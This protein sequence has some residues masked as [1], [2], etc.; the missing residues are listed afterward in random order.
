VYLHDYLADFIGYGESSKSFNV[1]IE[2][3]DSDEAQS[4]KGLEGEF[5]WKWLED[6]GYNDKLGELLLKSL[7]PALL[8]D[9]CQF[10][11]EALRCSNRGRLT[12]AYALLRKPL[13]EDLAYLEWMLGDPEF[14]LT[15]LYNEPAA[16]LALSV[17]TQRDRHLPIIQAAARRTT[18]ADMYNEDFIY[19]LRYTKGAYYGFDALWNKALHLVT[20]HKE[21]T[22]EPQ[23]LNFIFSGDDA[24][25]DQWDFLYSRLPFLLFYTADV[26][27]SLMT[28]ILGDLMPN[29]AERIVRRGIGLVACTAAGTDLWKAKN[30][31]HA[32]SA[33][34]VMSQLAIPCPK[35]GGSLG[36]PTEEVRTLYLNRRTRCASCHRQVTIADM[37]RPSDAA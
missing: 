24:R 17:L 9:F 20:T 37:V 15:T 30:E 8:A 3:K 5:I 29:A 4:L 18:N 11:Y 14:L 1:T 10:T 22:T 23:N 36:L 31:P 16:A 6:R 33:D 7:F 34:H 26:C 35:C 27:E 21:L 32:S 12:V 19:D 25:H 2:F 13:K 28:L